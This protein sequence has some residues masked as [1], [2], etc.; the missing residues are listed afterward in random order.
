M[1]I[2]Y[3]IL[4]TFNAG[5]MERVLANKANY[6]VQA[7][8]EI[9]IITTD[10]RARAS[11][12]EFDSRIKMLDLGINYT[13]SKQASIFRKIINYPLKQVQHYRRLNKVLQELKADI[14]IS[15]FDHEAPFLYKIADGSK[16]VLEIHFSRFKRQQYARAGILAYL[17]KRRSIQDSK[18]VRQYDRF[19]V[20]T[21]E[22]RNYWGDVPHIQ[23]IPNA[24]SFV[25]QATAKLLTQR[26]IAVGRYDH[27]KGFEDLIQAWVEVQAVA[28]DWCLHIFGNGPLQA[29]LQAQI[30]ALGLQDVVKLCAAVKNIEQEYLQSSILVLSSRYEGLPM[31]LLEAQ[32]CGLPLVSFACKCGPSDIIDQGIN[33]FLIP[34]RAVSLFAAGI[35]KLIADEKLRLQMGEQARKNSERFSQENIMTQWL[36]LF[37]SL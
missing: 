34:E 8:Y 11:Y 31:V 7:G 32:A 16:K 18:L 6:L 36:A 3:C 5:G 12:F 13:A 21:Q 25:P 23:V 4:G 19:V 29:S 17:D 24:N 37:K 2:V 26:V 22:D 28:P 10:Q 15:M 20:L 33:G 30:D 27:Q 9:C 14:V 1:K 35:V